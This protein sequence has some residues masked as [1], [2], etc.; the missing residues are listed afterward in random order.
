[1]Q[2]PNSSTVWSAFIDVFD[3]TYWAIVIIC[4]ICL[5]VVFYITWLS[6]ENEPQNNKLITSI[7]LVLLSHIGMSIS[8]SP[9]KIST[10]M[11]LLTVYITGMVIFWVYNS[12]LIS[13]LTVDKAELQVK[14][15]EVK[16]FVK[17][18]VGAIQKYVLI[19]EIILRSQ[20]PPCV[21]LCYL[22]GC[23]YFC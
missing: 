17:H 8:V 11:I 23:T 2:L 6:I 9:K 14:S 16:L 12:G 3:K 4:V 19:F 21:I 20:L 22:P 18:F 15:L 1:M 10:R 5:S 7:A 13:V